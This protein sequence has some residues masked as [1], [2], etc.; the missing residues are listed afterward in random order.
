MEGPRERKD[1]IPQRSPEAST[2]S[3]ETLNSL[4][5][6]IKQG[7]L[8]HGSKSNTIELEPR[9][10]RDTDAERITGNQVGVYAID[11][12]E[13]PI[14][15]ALRDK[16]NPLRPSRS[17]YSGIDGKYE[18]GGENVILTPG[19]IHVLP[20]DTFETVRD[21]KGNEELVSR[22]PVR[23]VAV[24]EVQ[25][26]IIKLLPNVTLNLSDEPPTKE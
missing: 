18:M 3:I 20:R 26:D 2:E 24:V 6:Y 12:V 21:E 14:F 13:E 10:A 7:Y 17:F 22:V 16:A 25:P 1:S 11:S 23:A 8:L 4:R 15:M 9:Q 19:Y 5:D